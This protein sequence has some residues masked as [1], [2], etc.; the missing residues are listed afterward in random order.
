MSS[1]RSPPPSPSPV[2]MKSPETH[3]YSACARMR[4][5]ERMLRSERCRL[6]VDAAVGATRLLLGRPAIFIADV[7]KLGELLLLLQHILAAGCT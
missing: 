3:E 5:R 6:I 7:S 1:S 4:G 2:K